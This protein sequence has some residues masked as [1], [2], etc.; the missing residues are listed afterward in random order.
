MQE[1]DRQTQ[2][3]ILEEQSSAEKK[4][5]FLCNP[6]GRKCSQNT[7]IREKRKH[8]KSSSHVI[9]ILYVDLVGVTCRA[10]FMRRH[11]RHVPMLAH[12]GGPITRTPT[13]LNEEMDLACFLSF[14]SFFFPLKYQSLSGRNFVS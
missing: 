14:F 13:G 1:G 7:W 9:F 10:G 6:R 3:N 2:A 4:N 5:R 8:K 12:P 11:S